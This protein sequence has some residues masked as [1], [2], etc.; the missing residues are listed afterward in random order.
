PVA[1]TEAAIALSIL[2][3]AR[4]ALVHDSASV[5]YR[6]PVVISAI[7][8]LLHGLGFA[9]ALGEVGLPD[10]EIPW[11]LLFFNVGVEAGQLTFILVV[12]TMF[13][14][15]R[16]ILASGRIATWLDL[17]GRVAAGYLIGIPAAFWLWQRI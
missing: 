17:H 11:A 10:R 1:P 5:A 2:F 12:A 16:R 4:E 14:L 15:A 6:Y 9:A 8:G 13:A 3:L 7:F